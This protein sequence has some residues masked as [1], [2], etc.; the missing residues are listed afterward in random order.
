LGDF[1]IPANLFTKHIN[2]K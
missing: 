2:D 1:P